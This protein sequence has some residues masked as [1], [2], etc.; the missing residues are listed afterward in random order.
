MKLWLDDVRPPPDETWLWARTVDEAK[1][2]SPQTE[3]SEQS[4]D[5]DLGSHGA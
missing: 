3:L 1:R 4:L 2:S 5:H